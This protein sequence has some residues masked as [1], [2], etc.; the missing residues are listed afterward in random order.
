M[1]HYKQNTRMMRYAHKVL[2][3]LNASHI[4]ALMSFLLLF[5]ILNILKKCKCIF[6]ER[7]NLIYN[8][9]ECMIYNIFD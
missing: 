4:I 6:F 2:L 5:S 8:V 9:Y 7:L 1:E 3:Y